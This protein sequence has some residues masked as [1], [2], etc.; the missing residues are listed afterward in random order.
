[1]ELKSLLRGEVIAAGDP[2]YDE[3]RKVHNGMIDRHPRLIARCADVAD[4]IAS[5]RYARDREDVPASVAACNIV[6][7]AASR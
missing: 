5:V 3:A 2:G 4:V 7:C 6:A 1:M